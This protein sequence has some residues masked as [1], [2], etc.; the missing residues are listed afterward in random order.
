VFLAYW[1][2]LPDDLLRPIIAYYAHVDTFNVL[3]GDFGTPT[4]VPIREAQ[5]AMERALS[6]AEELL[7]LMGN[8]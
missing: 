4:P 7:R 1:H 2:L 6:C 5:A 3:A 8:G